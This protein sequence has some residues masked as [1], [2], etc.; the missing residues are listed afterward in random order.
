MMTS[1]GTKMMIRRLR[2]RAF[3]IDMLQANYDGKWIRVMSLQPE[4]SPPTSP[5]YHFPGTS[6]RNHLMWLY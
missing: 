4:I 6:D 5:G 3:G 1:G 2:I